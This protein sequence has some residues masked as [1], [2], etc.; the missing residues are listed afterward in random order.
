MK[1]EIVLDGGLAILNALSHFAGADRLPAFFG[2]N[3]ARSRENALP[4]LLLFPLPA[5]FDS[6]SSHDPFAEQK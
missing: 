3:R 5:L 2:G 4:D 6:H 1:K